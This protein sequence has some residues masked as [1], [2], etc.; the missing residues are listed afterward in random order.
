MSWTFRGRR[1][2]VCLLGRPWHLDPH[3][4]LGGEREEGF[5]MEGPEPGGEQ[6]TVEGRLPSRHCRVSQPGTRVGWRDR[7]ESWARSRK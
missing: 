5:R 1:P 6:D 4:R 7:E 2:R 3:G